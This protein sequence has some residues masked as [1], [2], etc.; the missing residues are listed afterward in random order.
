[1]SCKATTNLHLHHMIISAVVARRIILSSSAYTNRL[2]LS[3]N[4]TGISAPPQS[5]M[6][7]INVP[8]KTLLGPGP[9]SAPPRV[10][11]AGSMPLLGHLHGEFTQVSIVIAMH[12]ALHMGLRS[13]HILACQLLESESV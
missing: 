10:L 4:M 12:A 1:M 6:K 3:R 5:L 9:S 7:P 8:Q 13:R 11:A 2:L